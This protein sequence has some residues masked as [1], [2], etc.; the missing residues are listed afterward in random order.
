MGCG[1]E[2]WAFWNSLGSLPGALL[3]RVVRADCGQLPGGAGRC[4]P[5]ALGTA[6]TWSARLVP[7][8]SR[9]SEQGPF[10]SVF[11]PLHTSNEKKVF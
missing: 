9:V 5:G 7:H 11:L 3:W 8:G 2:K 1:V 4:F 6:P 10:V